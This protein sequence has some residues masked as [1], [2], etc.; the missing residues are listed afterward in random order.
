MTI[1]AHTFQTAVD[2]SDGHS[3]TGGMRIRS[4]VHS[5]REGLEPPQNTCLSLRLML[6]DKSHK[7]P[8]FNVQKI[9]NSVNIQ[10]LQK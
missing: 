5:E 9:L 2:V 6:L 10:N 4:L 3:N 8:K 7:P 1:S